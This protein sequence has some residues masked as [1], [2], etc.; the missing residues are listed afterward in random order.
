MQFALGG[1]FLNRLVKVRRIERQR[2]F[3]VVENFFRFVT[4]VSIRLY[5]IHLSDLPNFTGPLQW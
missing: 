3:E 5:E 1:D 4:V 2:G